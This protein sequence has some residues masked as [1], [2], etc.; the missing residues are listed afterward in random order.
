M[1]SVQIQYSVFETGKITVSVLLE[2]MSV[3]IDASPDLL[4]LI[5]QKLCIMQYRYGSLSPK[6][7]KIWRQRVDWCVSFNLGLILLCFQFLWFDW[8][9]YFSDDSQNEM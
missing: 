5:Q 3:H 6:L 7:K 1:F 2:K 8:C 9:P 4:L